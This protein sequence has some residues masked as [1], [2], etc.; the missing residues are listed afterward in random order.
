MAELRH[1][2]REVPDFP[3]RG[4]LFKDITPLLLDPSAFAD[5]ISQLAA[6][7]P[8]PEAVVA[9]ESRGFVFGATL[10]LEWRVPFVPARKFGKLPGRTMRQVYSLEYG[11]DTLE[12][13]TD[14]L[15]RGQRVVIV[16]DL[17]AT[18]GTAAAAAKL[19][20]QLDAR[21]DALLFVIELAGQG[22]REKLSPHRVEAE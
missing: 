9:I 22:G 16:D 7:V 14:A 15:R 4:I 2:I 8:R 12:I 3:H 18:G 5:C 10:A 20:E 1:L 13:H 6:R 11:E 21:I 17:L 19:V